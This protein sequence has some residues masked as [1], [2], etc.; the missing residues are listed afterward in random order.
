MSFIIHRIVKSRFNGMTS[1]LGFKPTFR[2]SPSLFLF[3]FSL[4]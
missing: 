3:S 4:F 2:P 1:I